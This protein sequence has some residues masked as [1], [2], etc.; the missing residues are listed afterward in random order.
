MHLV[1]LSAASQRKDRGVEL[2]PTL[3]GGAAQ[4]VIAK[5][6]EAGLIEEVRAKGA[7]PVRRRDDENLAYAL[8]ITRAGMK[9]IAADEGDDHEEN[10][11]Q[12]SRPA[13]RQ[14]INRGRS[15]RR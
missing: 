12:M 2:P 8:R 6:I 5:L 10:T 11:D 15:R 4:K 3:K 9:A 1:I 7:M 14:P 13:G